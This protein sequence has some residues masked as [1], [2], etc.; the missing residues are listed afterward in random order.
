MTDT[1]GTIDPDETTVH[2]TMERIAG[3]GEVFRRFGLDTCCGGELPLATAAEH[4]GVDLDRL[5]GALERAAGGS[6]AGG[7]AG[8]GGDAAGRE[9]GGED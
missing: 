4:H 9:S 8:V 1:P 7:P 6:D 2:E 3:A 5:L